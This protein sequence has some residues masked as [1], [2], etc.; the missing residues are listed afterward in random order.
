MLSEMGIF[1]YVLPQAGLGLDELSYRSFQGLDLASVFITCFFTY[2]QYFLTSQTPSV[3]DTRGLSGP[4]SRNLVF[5]DI[6][7]TRSG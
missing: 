4:P 5:C 7:A 6:K 2:S 3:L 1:C